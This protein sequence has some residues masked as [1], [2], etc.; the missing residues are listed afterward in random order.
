MSTGCNEHW[1]L[2]SCEWYESTEVEAIPIQKA[3]EARLQDQEMTSWEF[4][5]QI[6][7]HLQNVETCFGDA[8]PTTTTK[9]KKKYVLQISKT[10]V[11]NFQNTL[12]PSSRCLPNDHGLR[13]KK[14]MFFS[15]Q[16][17]RRRWD[18]MLLPQPWSCVA[19]LKDDLFDIKVYEAFSCWPRPEIFDLFGIYDIFL[20]LCWTLQSVQCRCKNIYCIHVYITNILS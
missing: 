12:Q 19:S 7:T 13:T 3:P 10:H 14:S 15:S 5:Y 6:K 11:A 4:G 9:K 20:K 17:A 16:A 8:C 1:I 18:S 2:P